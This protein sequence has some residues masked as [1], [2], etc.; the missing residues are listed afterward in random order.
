MKAG[1]KT[2]KLGDIALVGAGNSA[3]QDDADFSTDGPYFV[4]TS[5]VG[6]VKF[7]TVNSSNDR[8]SSK[9]AKGMRLWKEG[10]ILIP[11]SGASTFVNHRVILGLD[12]H[13]SSH[14]ATIQAEPTRCDAR[15]LLYYLSTVKAQDLIQDQS[16]PSLKLPEIAGIEIPLPP[17]AEQKRIVAL[18]DEAFAGIDEAKA[19]AEANMREAAALFASKLEVTFL[20]SSQKWS[21][22]SVGEMISDR[23]G[24]VKTGPF[25]TKLSASEYGKEGVP[26]IS[27]GE[28]R[29]G[30]ILLHT[31]TPKVGPSVTKRMPEYLLEKGDIVFGRKGGVERS[32]YIT[33]REAGWFLGSDGIRLRLPSSCDKLFIAYQLLRPAHQSWMKSKATG[34]T[35]PSLNQGIIENIPILLCDYDLQCSIVKELERFETQSKPLKDMYIKKMSA[36]KELKSA[37]LA[38]AFAG[39]LTA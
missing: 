17:V 37:I 1:W 10:T 29:M 23:Q 24:E 15:Y 38:Q 28:I 33:D 39:E 16:Y 20:P 5:D 14:L 30:E 26:V 31:R 19:K 21:N 34:T 13:V 9:G 2:V 22:S 18:L 7:G 11:K 4:R 25:G 3:P 12:A 32:A 8:L 35:M 6:E 36:L 27:V